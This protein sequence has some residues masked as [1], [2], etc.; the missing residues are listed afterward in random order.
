MA[1]GAF[2]SWKKSGKRPH[3]PGAVRALCG[4]A[5]AGAALRGTNPINS[6]SPDWELWQPP[7]FPGKRREEF[8]LFS[9][10]HFVPSFNPLELLEPAPK[11]FCG[12]LEAAER[13]KYQIFV[14]WNSPAGTA[15]AQ[16]NL[17]PELWLSIPGVFPAGAA[18]R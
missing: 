9:S 8:S 14:C 5:A 1:K 12:K 3:V 2:S 11:S 13:I 7:G 15:A 17:W 16:D 4:R 18:Q 10:L 6:S